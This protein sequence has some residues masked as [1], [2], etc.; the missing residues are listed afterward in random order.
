MSVKDYF[1]FDIFTTNTGKK[2]SW[3]SSSSFLTYP[4]MMMLKSGRTIRWV[5][6]ITSSLEPHKVLIECSLH[7]LYIIFV[8]NISELI[9]CHHF[10]ISNSC[11]NQSKIFIQ[12]KV[13][14][15]LSLSYGTIIRAW[16]QTMYLII[17]IIF[18]KSCFE[19]GAEIEVI[20]V[21]YIKNYFEVAMF[22]ILSQNNHYRQRDLVQNLISILI[23]LNENFLMLFF[24][25]KVS[26]WS[27]IL[28]TS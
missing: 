24:S 25:I 8:F 4:R 1:I 14:F 28:T 12:Y 15:F 23:T 5:E 18:L 20:L 9:W 11:N 2:L 6:S 26:F 17:R 3:Y 22:Y 19:Y 7:Y 10:F 13:N 27:I 21:R 16:H